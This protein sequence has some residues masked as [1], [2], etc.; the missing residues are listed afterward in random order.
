MHTKSVENMYVL[1]DEG[2]QGKVR[3]KSLSANTTKCWAKIKL[4]FT[5]QVSLKLKLLYLMSQL[6]KK[7][8]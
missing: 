5:D 6:S 8:E 4:K 2:N 1:H 3:D 7:S